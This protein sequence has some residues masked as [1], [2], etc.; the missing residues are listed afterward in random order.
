M[1]Q[2][3]TQNPDQALNP[4]LTVRASLQRPLVRLSGLSSAERRRRADALLDAV[5]LRPEFSRRLPSQLSGGEKQRVAI[6]RALAAETRV[7]LCD[8][9][10]SA[11][12]VSVQ[13]RIL[14]L[15]VDLQQETGAGYL[16]ISHDLAVVAHLADRVAVMYLGELMESGRTEDVLSPPHH[17]Y[18]EAL[19]S[20]VP[21]LDGDGQRIRLQGEIPSPVHR[22][23]GCPFHT[24]CPRR[25]GPICD[26]ESP[27]WRHGPSE[28]LV[29][30]H[31][32]L[33]TLST[34]QGRKHGTDA[35]LPEEER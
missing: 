29:V 20:S 23:S 13:A 9:A 3:V 15:L 2:A 16:F 34:V 26:T 32:P 22:P 14:N 28:H 33:E 6:A 27:P 30:C 18:T 8:E 11:L 25:V 31:I 35:E 24:R 1:L 5:G 7:L 19:L 12:D 17:P 4:H 21:S 10:T